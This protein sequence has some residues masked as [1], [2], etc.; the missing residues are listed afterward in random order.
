MDTCKEGDHDMHEV[1]VMQGVVKT[2]L[3]SLSQA[4][5]SRVTNVQLAIGR[6]GHFTEENARLYFAVLTKNTPIEGASLTISWLPATLQCLSCFH[7]FS[8]CEL[9]ER[10]MCPKCGDMVMEI[11]HQDICYV[12]AIDVISEEE[13]SQIIRLE[14]DGVWN[15]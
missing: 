2:I 9:A 7:R 14:A 1:A 6:S 8:S 3:Q 12:S 10:T 11:E 4:G 5:A 15:G 13:A